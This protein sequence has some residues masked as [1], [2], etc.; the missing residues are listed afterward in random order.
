[1][2]KEKSNELLASEK[3]AIEI[4]H[5]EKEELKKI[6][7]E[8]RLSNKIDIFVNGLEAIT[9]LEKNISYI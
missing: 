2:E 4:K 6:I 8:S 5:A 9:F 3:D 7:E 1:M